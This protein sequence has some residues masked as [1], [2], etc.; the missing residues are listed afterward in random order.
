MAKRTWE[1]E[2]AYCA[3]RAEE[4]KAEMTRATENVD[5]AAFTEAYEKSM[6][7]MKVKER[8]RLY[9]AFTAYSKTPEMQAFLAGDMQAFLAGMTKKEGEGA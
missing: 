9:V 6:R 2:K 5:L 7:Y 1:Q 4:L 8:R 3:K